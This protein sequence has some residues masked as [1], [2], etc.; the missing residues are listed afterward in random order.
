MPLNTQIIQLIETFQ[1]QFFEN[2]SSPERDSWSKSSGLP[3]WLA[4]NLLLGSGASNASKTGQR[5]LRFKFWQQWSVSF[6][7]FYIKAS[8][9]SL[10]FPKN[11]SHYISRRR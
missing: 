3:L 9:I 6:H 5:H 8:Q 2:L 11:F 10:R 1:R 7:I 4:C